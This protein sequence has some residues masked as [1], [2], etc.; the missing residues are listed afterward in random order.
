MFY[1]IEANLGTTPYEKG[2]MFNEISVQGCLLMIQTAEPELA[3]KAAR[4]AI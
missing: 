3:S 4:L 1:Q 2:K